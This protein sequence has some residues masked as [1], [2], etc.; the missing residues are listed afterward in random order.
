MLVSVGDEV[1][2]TVGVVVA[3]LVVAVVVELVCD[4]GLVVVVMVLKELW[5]VGVVLSL[6][7]VGDEVLM[8]VEVV[9]A[10]LAVAVVVEHISLCW[11]LQLSLLAWKL[12]SLLL[13]SWSFGG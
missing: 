3:V 2:V 13:C 4:G 9:V 12:Q 1:L 6:A 11:F 7:S 8:T 10:V 5:A